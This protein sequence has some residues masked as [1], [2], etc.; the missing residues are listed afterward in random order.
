[1]K[2]QS[3]YRL[4]FG[5]R[6]LQLQLNLD[7]DCCNFLRLLQEVKNEPFL[8]TELN[9]WLRDQRPDLASLLGAEL[10]LKAMGVLNMEGLRDQ[11]P[12]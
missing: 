12:I 1:M 3:S 7:V 2:I 6:L 9:K 8:P 4:G 10:R 11:D 5:K